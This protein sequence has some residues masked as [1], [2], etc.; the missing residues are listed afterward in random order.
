MTFGFSL[1]PN[2]NEDEFEFSEPMLGLKSRTQELGGLV[3]LNWRLQILAPCECCGKAENL[4][5]LSGLKFD[6]A[7]DYL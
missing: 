6:V 7:I 4:W 1:G 3:R 2:G 5:T